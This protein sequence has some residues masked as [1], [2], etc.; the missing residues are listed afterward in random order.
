M[1]IFDSYV[2]LPEGIMIFLV[3]L[4]VAL[5]LRHFSISICWPPW[6]QTEQ[7]KILIDGFLFSDFT[8]QSIAHRIHGAGIYMLTFGVYGW[9]PCYHI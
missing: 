8:S 2:S 1:V 9:D 7:Q 3:C 5:A 6:K 4:C